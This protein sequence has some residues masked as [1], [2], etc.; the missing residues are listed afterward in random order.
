MVCRYLAV[1]HTA[2]AVT[3]SSVAAGSGSVHKRSMAST[4]ADDAQDSVGGSRKRR[5]EEMGC[6]MEPSAKHQRTE[7]QAQQFLDSIIL[8]LSK[9]GKI[10]IHPSLYMPVVLGVS[11]V[12]HSS[13]CSPS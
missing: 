10:Q 5:H 13:E 4:N 3:D 1:L 11:A 7:L 12:A 9:T 2:V 6:G 8:I